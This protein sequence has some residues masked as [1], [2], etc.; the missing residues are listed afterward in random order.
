MGHHHA[1]PVGVLVLLLHKLT[2]TRSVG[3]ATAIATEL[4][5]IP[6]ATLLMKVSCTSTRH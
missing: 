5:V 3:E 2:F 4:V 6:A 1:S